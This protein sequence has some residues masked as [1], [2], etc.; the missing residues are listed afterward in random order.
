MRVQMKSSE[1]KISRTIIHFQLSGDNN[2]HNSLQLLFITPLV[3]KCVCMCGCEC[4]RATLNATIDTERSKNDSISNI[5][6]CHL[7]N[8]HFIFHFDTV[9][10]FN[11]LHFYTNIDM[12]L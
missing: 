7:N 9:D 2:R 4:V 8:F 3:C 11:T 1:N 12:P 6:T 10:K 5:D